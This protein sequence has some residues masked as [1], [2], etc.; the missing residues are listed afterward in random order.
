METAS[1]IGSMKNEAEALKVE[2][3]AKSLAERANKIVDDVWKNCRGKDR[4]IDLTTLASDDTPLPV[5]PR[6]PHH[7]CKGA[8]LLQRAEPEDESVSMIM[9][10]TGRNDSWGFTCK[11]CSL[12]VG[13]YQALRI[14][15]GRP[16]QSKLLLAASHLDSNR[17]FDDFRAYYRCLCCAEEGRTVD[18][19]NAIAFECHMQKH[20]GFQPKRYDQP[21]VVVEQT[22]EELLQFTSRTEDIHADTAGVLPKDVGVVGDAWVQ[23]GRNDSTA[24]SVYELPSSIQPATTSTVSEQQARYSV[25]SPHRQV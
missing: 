8:I 22:A 15:K 5:E 1:K 11:Y 10:T 3:E 14:S 9:K 20:V 16:L 21:D 13:D 12:T 17:S 19:G 4:S 23:N 24:A 25:W 18:F 7:F 6:D 2:N